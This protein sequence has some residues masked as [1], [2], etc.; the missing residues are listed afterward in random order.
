MRD[1]E[2]HRE[3]H[4]QGCRK[5]QHWWQSQGQYCSC[6]AAMLVQAKEETNQHLIDTWEVGG[7]ET[8]PIVW[9]LH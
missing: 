8:A 1:S 6:Q 4:A 2:L 7:L 9:K 5:Q 3:A